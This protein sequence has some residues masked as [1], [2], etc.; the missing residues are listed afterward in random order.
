M[1]LQG[2]GGPIICGR[3]LKKKKVMASRA[4][5][6]EFALNEWKVPTSTET[7]GSKWRMRATTGKFVDAG[8]G[9]WRSANRRASIFTE[10][11]EVRHLLGWECDVFGGL[12]SGKS[13]RWED[14]WLEKWEG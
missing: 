5:V 3:T 8:T 14:S 7:R 6:E 11:L 9:N 1:E 4:L 10:R 2:K 13:E 12:E